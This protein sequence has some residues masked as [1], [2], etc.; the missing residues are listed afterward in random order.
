MV[1]NTEKNM[2]KPAYIIGTGIIVIGVLGWLVYA[3]LPVAPLQQPPGSDVAS[4]TTPGVTVETVAS[5]LDAP[6]AIDFTHTGDIFF[7]ERPGRVRL[8]EDGTLQDQPLLD[9]PHADS[10]GGT[11]GLALDPDFAD[12]QYV[13][14]YY[15]TAEQTN[16]IS[17]FRFNGNEFVEEKKLVDNIPGAA[18]HNGGRIAFGPNG[19]LYAGTG[20]ARTPSSAQD[21]DSLAGKILRINPDGDTPVDNPNGNSYVY[22][23]G[24]R[25]VQGLAWDEDDNLYA[26]EHGSQAKDEINRIQPDANYGWPEVEG[27]FNTQTGRPPVND[28]RNPVKSSGGVTWAPSGATFYTGNEFPI[29]WHDT[30]LFAGL[31]SQSIW[32]FDPNTNK[33]ERLFENVYGR[34][35]TIQQSPDG[36]LYMLTSNRDGR[37]EPSEDDDRI[38]R[39]SPKN[40]GLE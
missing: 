35:R 6:W 33:V 14:I 5:N 11:L 1:I 29:V 34:L 36:D 21:K 3:H 8:I 16:R 31:R 10:E 30:L 9:L 38:L 25:N 7:T 13:Y 32:R 37:G 17:R 2:K 19:K 20:D 18:F 24:H 28:Y 40:T 12:N 15:T 22:S 27:H 26:T 4:T 23:Y 39:I